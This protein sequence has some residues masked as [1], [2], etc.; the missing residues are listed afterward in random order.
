MG[1][2][3]STAHGACGAVRSSGMR[4][5]WSE[6]NVE[7][8]IFFLM[9]YTIELL[10]APST[11]GSWLNFIPRV[12]DIIFEVETCHPPGPQPHAPEREAS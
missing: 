9:F 1:T 4:V 7:A 8:A 10:S 3:E 12:S 6:N 2:K 11:S 5:R